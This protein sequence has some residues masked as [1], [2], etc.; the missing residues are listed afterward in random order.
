MA[1]HVDATL[2]DL[3]DKPVVHGPVVVPLLGLARRPGDIEPDPGGAQGRVAVQLLGELRVVVPGDAAT[4]R[5]SRA[6][7]RGRRCGRRSCQARGTVRGS[8][9]G[10]GV[11]G[12]ERVRA[13]CRASPGPAASASSPGAAGI[14]AAAF[15]VNRCAA[16]CESRP[17]RYSACP[18]SAATSPSPQRCRRCGVPAD[19]AQPED[20]CHGRMLAH[21]R[22]P[23]D[24]AAHEL[25]LQRSD[26][27]VPGAVPLQR[28][29]LGGR[30]RRRSRFWSRAPRGGSLHRRE[31]EKGDENE[32]ADPAGAEHAALQE[33][34]F[35]LRR[36]L[37]CPSGTPR[38]P[39][40]P[41]SRD[42]HPSVAV[43]PSLDR[44]ACPRPRDKVW[45]WFWRHD[46]VDR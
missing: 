15:S 40:T 38:G 9:G 30:A 24:A 39:S 25:A 32:V 7:F 3:R 46:A 18:D 33:R 43:D 26:G 17:R 35:R 29:L 1:M 44:G 10:A 2:P 19:W 36:R 20:L 12:A 31:T 37:L 45:R 42:G 22:L 27:R 11:G 14:R 34:S 21:E 6:R 13:A 5:R 8:V 41:R 23:V 4:R 28:G 16:L